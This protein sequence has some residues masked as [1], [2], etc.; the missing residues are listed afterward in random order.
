MSTTTATT[1]APK[2]Q[3]KVHIKVPPLPYLAV[4]QTPQMPMEII[5]FLF[6]K[7]HIQSA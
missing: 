3:E 2:I 1:T 4:G 5:Q 6:F 7:A